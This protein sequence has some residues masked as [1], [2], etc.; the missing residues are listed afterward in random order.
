MAY[1]KILNSCWQRGTEISDN[2]SSVLRWIPKAFLLG[3]SLNTGKNH[4]NFSYALMGYKLAVITLEKDLCL[5]GGKKKLS[6]NICSAVLW[7]PK[8]QRAQWV[9]SGEM[10]EQN[11]NLSIAVTWI[12]ALSLFLNASG[13][14]ECQ[15]KCYKC[16]SLVAGYPLFGFKVRN[17]SSFYFYL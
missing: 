5:T 13:I 2:A 1:M 6:E 4:L 3:S 17:D 12:G 7:W 11:W 10:V 9:I 15:G 16:A 8:E 14:P